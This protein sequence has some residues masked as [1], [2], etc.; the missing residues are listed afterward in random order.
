VQPGD[1]AA[2][3]SKKED[4]LGQVVSMPLSNEFHWLSSSS[5]NS[6]STTR[7]DTHLRINQVNQ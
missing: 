3:A 7:P 1:A 2:A 6:S 5:S 4:S